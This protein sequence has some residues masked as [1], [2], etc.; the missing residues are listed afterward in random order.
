MEAKSVGTFCVVIQKQLAVSHCPLPKGSCVWKHRRTGL[1]CYD[2]NLSD[3]KL[4]DLSQ[5]VGLRAPTEDQFLKTRA[6]LLE[7]IQSELKG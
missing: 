6:E 2:L 5:L 3:I 7:A 4:V 1:C